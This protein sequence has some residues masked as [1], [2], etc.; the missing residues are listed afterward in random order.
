MGNPHASQMRA[1]AAIEARISIGGLNVTI[2]RMPGRSNTCVGGPVN[3][4]EGVRLRKSVD[5]RTWPNRG[6]FGNGQDKTAALMYYT[7][8]WRCRTVKTRRSILGNTIARVIG[9]NSINLCRVRQ[10]SAQCTW[11]IMFSLHTQL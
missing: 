5:G 1:I 11:L 9:V 7:I 3:W 4:Y 6:E 8:L 2:T 10:S